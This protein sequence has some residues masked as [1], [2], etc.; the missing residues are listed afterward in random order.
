MVHNHPF[1]LLKFWTTGNLQM[2]QLCTLE[3]DGDREFGL[4]LVVLFRSDIFLIQFVTNTETWKSTSW[5]WL[6]LMKVYTCIPTIYML[7]WKA[8]KQSFNQW[9]I[10]PPFCMNW[11]LLYVWEKGYIQ[12]IHIRTSRIYQ[13]CACV[14]RLSCTLDQPYDRCKM[15]WRG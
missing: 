1:S 4:T 7:H 6:W 8:E 9:S 14:Y 2:A 12:H 13:S 5:K 11:K 10:N 15:L 3:V